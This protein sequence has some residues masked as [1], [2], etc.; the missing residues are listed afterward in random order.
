M[1]SVWHE[2]HWT[3]HPPLAALI[4]LAGMITVVIMAAV[5]CTATHASV[6]AYRQP[7]IDPEVRAIT[8]SAPARVLVELSVPETDSA[9]RPRAIERAQD[10]LLD[11][12]RGT[13]TRVF[14]RYTS[15]PALALEIDAEALA[16]LEAMSDLVSRVR[17]DTVVGPSS[18]RRAAGRPG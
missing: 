13:S 1:P 6:P 7:A 2:R 14:R 18:H 11:R 9:L 8:R 16:R 17:M 10:E 12:L 3:E 5:S 15:V 4:A